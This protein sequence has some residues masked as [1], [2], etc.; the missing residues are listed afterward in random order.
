MS[1]QTYQSQRHTI[2][3][4]ERLNIET[5]F[6]YFMVLSNSGSDLKYEVNERP[7]QEVPTLLPVPLGGASRLSIH[8]DT[9]A[10]V[11]IWIAFSNEKLTA[12]KTEIQGNVSV[13][14][15]GDEVTTAAD[16]T[17]GVKASIASAD[18]TRKEAIVQLISGNPCR[19]GDTNITTS[20][21]A[22]LA[23]AG[24]SITINSTAEI[25]A[26]AESGNSVLAVVE[27]GDA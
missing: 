8:N 7:E 18:T 13:T 1:E 6:D 19:V 22:R 12:S 2:A 17:V 23:N 10:S 9:G 3:N 5:Q 11:S 15:A 16:Q 24:D 27:L 26:I 20:R 21:G 4:G 14:F 25:F